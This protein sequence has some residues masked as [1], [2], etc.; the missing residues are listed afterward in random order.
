MHKT[1]RSL[2]SGAARLGLHGNVIV[3]PLPIVF[4][5]TFKPPNK[6]I[7]FLF[8]VP[9]PIFSRLKIVR[10]VALSLLSRIGLMISVLVNYMTSSCPAIS[11]N[12][13]L[14]TL[15]WKTFVKTHHIRVPD[16]PTTV[17]ELQ[18]TSTSPTAKDSPPISDTVAPKHPAKAR[19]AAKKGLTTQTTTALHPLH[20]ISTGPPILPVASST[21]PAVSHAPPTPPF[22][23][24]LAAQSPVL[25]AD[26][27]S[28]DI[29]MTS[30]A[31]Y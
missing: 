10:Q 1:S 17:E 12:V 18:Q 22:L 28:S 20:T 7:N 27:T 16:R 15:L 21:V 24:A 26:A 8:L 3:Q 29:D 31:R 9:P 23:L 30:Q 2:V 25:R 5:H 4:N 11:N 14:I 19:V 13:R 6:M